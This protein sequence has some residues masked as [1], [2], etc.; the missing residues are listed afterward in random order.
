M[1]L[2]RR[3]KSHLIF[4]CHVDD[5]R[6]VGDGPPLSFQRYL[7]IG[8]QYGHHHCDLPDGLSYWAH[9]A[10]L[11]LEEL[12]EEDLDR[13]KKHYIKLAEKAR[14]DLRQ[15]KLDT[16][17]PEVEPVSLEGGFDKIN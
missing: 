14:E 13:I 11:D 3:R 4:D 16:G 7:A 1:D 17:H 5:Y 9:N 10:L 12:T 6:L 15:G 8:D 2:A